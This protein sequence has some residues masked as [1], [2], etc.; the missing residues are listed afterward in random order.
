VLKNGEEVAVK[1]QYPSVSFYQEGD[2]LTHKIVSFFLAKFMTDYREL[3]D[4]FRG[5]L[6]KQL[7]FKME[8]EN[9]KLAAKNFSNRDDIYV[10]QIV[11]KYTSARVLTMEFIHGV[12][13]NDL[14][15]IHKWGFSPSTIA[16]TLFDAVGE[17]IFFAWLRPRRLACWQYFCQ[18]TSQK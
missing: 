2:L 6:A 15:T 4:D 5:V 17:Q 13:I 7:N 10:P 18:T 12:K 1:V 8:G 14:S 9:A 11:D 16:H 3:S